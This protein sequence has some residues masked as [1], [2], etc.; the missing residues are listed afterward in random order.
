[1]KALT[2]PRDSHGLFDYENFQNIRNT[3][4]VE[5]N[6]VLA[7]LDN[8]V[9]VI[10]KAEERGDLHI[11]PSESMTKLV[12]CTYDNGSRGTGHCR[13]VLHP[14]L[15]L[16]VHLR[17]PSRAN[18]VQHPVL[19]D[20]RPQKSTLESHAQEL[21][22]KRGDIMKLG[23]VTLLVKDF[24]IENAISPT[25]QVANPCE[26][27]PLDVQSSKNAPLYP[28]FYDTLGTALRNPAASAIQRSRPQGT[29]C[30]RSA[31]VPGRCGIST[32]SVCRSG[33]A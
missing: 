25:D 11:P 24:R 27:N 14:E 33:S 22:L 7:R 4:K 9:K 2:W 15:F 21:Y 3:L 18:V 13:Q 31:T 30:C 19:A 12:D 1:M 8:A 26:G 10:P 32:A 28:P 20:P 17:Y 23:R 5:G 16:Q 29:R 6:C